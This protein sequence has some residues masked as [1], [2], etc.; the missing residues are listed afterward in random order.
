MQKKKPIKPARLV[1]KKETVAT[2]TTA[3]LKNV[4]GGAIPETKIS[5]CYSA[6][7]PS[8]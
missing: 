7:F 8:C 2:L 4:A 3:M 5:H 1:V 6:C